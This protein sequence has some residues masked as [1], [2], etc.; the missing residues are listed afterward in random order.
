MNFLKRK[1][2]V[3]LLVVVFMLSIHT[4]YAKGFGYETT[5]E[6]ASCGECTCTYATE[7][8]YIFWIKVA[9]NRELTTI[10]CLD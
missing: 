7:S 5:V 10:N 9:S 6:T 4:T 1:I 3:I 8:L 2:N